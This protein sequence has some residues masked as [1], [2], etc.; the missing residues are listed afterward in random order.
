MIILK[1]NLWRLPSPIIEGLHYSIIIKT[2]K[3]DMMKLFIHE[4]TSFND[5][6]DSWSNVLKAS[7]KGIHIITSISDYYI[8]RIINIDFLIHLPW[9][10]L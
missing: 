10:A 9:I 7:K 6:F 4:K 8:G 2:D 3:D 1:I 5:Y